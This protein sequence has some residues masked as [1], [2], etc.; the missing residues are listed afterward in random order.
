MKIRAAI[1]VPFTAIVLFTAAGVVI[2]AAPNRIPPVLALMVPFDAPIDLET[3]TLCADNGLPGICP[4]SDLVFAFDVTQPS[5]PTVLVQQF[6]AQIAFLPNVPFA[7]V[8]GTAVANGLVFT[9]EVQHVP[10]GP[11][12]TA[13]I[14]T[15][16]GNYF[17]VGLAL[18][19]LPEYPGCAKVVQGGTYGVRFQ[20]QQLR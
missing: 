13:V 10:F 15:P 11:N 18:C 16:E 9:D 20:Y 3:G 14:H 8:D 7:A 2:D 17:K 1:L 6:R 12:D 5:N 19:F 4:T